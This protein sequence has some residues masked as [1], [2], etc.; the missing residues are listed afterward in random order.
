MEGGGGEPRISAMSILDENTMAIKRMN[1]ISTDRSGSRR[2]VSCIA[3]FA[4]G[5][6][7]LKRRDERLCLVCGDFFIFGGD[8]SAA[9]SEPENVCVL[10]FRGSVNR[11]QRRSKLAR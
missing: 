4:A 10:R 3:F 7:E 11:G 6:L 1:D 9:S 2:N 8:I 5:N